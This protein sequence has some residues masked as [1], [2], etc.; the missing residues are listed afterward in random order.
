MQPFLYRQN[1]L[2]Y[3]SVIYIANKLPSEVDENENEVT[4]YDTPKKYV[5]NVQYIDSDSATREWGERVTNMLVATIP[6][7]IY[8][9][10]FKEFDKVYIKT[11]PEN[12]F[13]NGDNADY[14]IYGIR[15]QNVLI[16]LYFTKLV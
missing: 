1:T 4:K 16:K 5:F 14:R 7:S 8:K 6:R 9:D 15:E 13:E 10:K 3:K 12:E 2:N 11:S